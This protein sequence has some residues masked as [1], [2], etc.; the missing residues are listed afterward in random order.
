M[1]TATTTRD[2]LTDEMLARFD[3]RAP[4]YDRD[5]RF[6]TEDFED[7]RN[8]GYL[9]ITRPEEYG[10]LGMRLSEFVAM[11]KKLAYVAPATAVA[12]NM[13]LFWVGL[14]ADLWRAGDNSCEFILREA[15]DGKIFAAGHG[16]A[17]ND[18]PLLLST[19]T[20]ERTEGG[21]NITG[22]KIFGS[23]SPVW[24]Y[25][26]VHAMDTSNPNAPQIVHGFLKR[27]AKNYRI[28]PTWDT[29]GM[30]A[31]Q[32]DDTILEGAFVPD[33]NVALVCPAGFAGA[34]LFQVGLFA[35][36]LLGFGAVYT[37]IAK[38]A[39]DMTI[40]KM[41]QRSSIALTRSMA[42][43]PEVQHYV[44]EMRMNLETI[45]AYL[46]R[47]AADWTT[48]VEHPDWPLKIVSTKHVVTTKAFDVVDRALD[49]SGGAGIF[50][51]TRLEQLFRDAR[52]GRVHPANL[53]LTHELVAKLSLGVN[54]DESP[55]WG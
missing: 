45:E 46:D 42:Y 23:L 15:A 49:L 48:G 14:A 25:L 53:L 6:F 5:N 8:S 12:V 54:P 31:T 35:W 11:Q 19:A 32:S 33:E 38:R 24:D 28:E 9:D 13:H 41:P 20:A 26:G 36:A 7:L 27:D 2:V 37:G 47:T 4:E 1:T 17:G 40:E 44:A 29:L 34:G 50:K 16:E 55:R 3:E 30:R 21:W 18:L 51:R 22:H 39:Y 10:G 52:L 43:H